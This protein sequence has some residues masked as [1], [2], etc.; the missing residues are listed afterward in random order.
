MQDGMK[1]THEACTITCKQEPN[2][3]PTRHEGCNTLKEDATAPGDSP[4]N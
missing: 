2:T 4:M 1:S 3:N